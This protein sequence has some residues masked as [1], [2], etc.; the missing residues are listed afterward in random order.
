MFRRQRSYGVEIR[1]SGTNVERDGFCCAHCPRHLWLGRDVDDIGGR[2]SS[3]DK[4]ICNACVG[5]GCMPLEYRLDQWER[6]G[7][8]LRYD[9]RDLLFEIFEKSGGKVL[10]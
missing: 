3:C 9:K 4:F 5:K 7:Q 1:P 6:R 8:G 2:C 10:K